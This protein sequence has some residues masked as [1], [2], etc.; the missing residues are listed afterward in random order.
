MG[1]FISSGTSSKQNDQDGLTLYYHPLSFYSQ[2][3]S[4]LTGKIKIDSKLN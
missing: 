1:Q 4:I 3:V 2:K